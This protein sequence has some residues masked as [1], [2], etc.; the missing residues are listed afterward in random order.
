MVSGDSNGKIVLWN[1]RSEILAI[2]EIVS[3]EV[4]LEVCGVWGDVLM[5]GYGGKLFELGLDRNREFWGGE[6]EK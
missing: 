5:F 1:L 4:G 6:L 2:I 3:E